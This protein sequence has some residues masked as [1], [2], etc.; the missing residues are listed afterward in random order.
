VPIN[1]MSE[2][3]GHS[4]SSFT[5]DAY[6]HVTPALEEQA[7]ATVARLVFGHDPLRTAL[8]AAC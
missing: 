5:A 8:S 4:T 7:A 3:L 2:R 6:Q 1:V